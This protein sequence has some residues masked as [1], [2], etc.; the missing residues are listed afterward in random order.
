MDPHPKRINQAEKY[1]FFDRKTN[2]VV[3]ARADALLD[4]TPVESKYVAP[5]SKE[6]TVYDTSQTRAERAQ[7]GDEGHIMVLS[8]EVQAGET[9]DVRPSTRLA[10]KSDVYFYDPQRDAITFKWKDGKWEPFTGPIRQ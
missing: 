9:P 3:T 7:G 10:E 6:K 4:K 1:E 8:T 2:R 5:D